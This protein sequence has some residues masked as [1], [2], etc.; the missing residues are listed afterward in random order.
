MNFRVPN[1]VAPGLAIS[2]RLTYL[3]RP[4]NEVIAAFMK[5]S[6]R[7][8]IKTNAAAGALLGSVS[9]VKCR[10]ISK[11]DCDADATRKD[12]DIALRPQVPNL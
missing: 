11:S 6:R 1:G 10:T 3:G 5:R 9:A 8:F 12:I 4:S 7:D 2:V